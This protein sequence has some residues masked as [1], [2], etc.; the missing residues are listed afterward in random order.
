MNELVAFW[1][2]FGLS[3]W[4]SLQLGI[5]NLQVIHTTLNHHKRQ[6]IMMAIGGV[7]PEFIYTIVAIYSVDLIK[8]N[9]VL[10]KWLEYL[11]VPVLIIMGVYMIFQKPK[12]ELKP[13]TSTGSF[14]KGFVLASL[15]PQLITYWIAWLVV[16]H[17][18][19]I[20]DKYTFFS[21]KISFAIGAAL[22]AFA[23]LRIFIF[24][25]DRYKSFLN[26]WLKIRLN[27]IIGIV[28]ILAAILVVVKNVF[29]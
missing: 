10:F 15:N 26:R 20:F 13:V 3:F 9:E 27:V 7:V 25:A 4:G 28:F 14:F 23:I 6:A 22:G 11:V 18:I 1:V 16:L 5:V 8:Q 2:A 17:N 21:P 24:L 12:A 19:V 29:F